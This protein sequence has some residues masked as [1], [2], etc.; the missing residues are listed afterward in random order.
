[1]RA[2]LAGTLFDLVK[3]EGMSNTTVVVSG[4]TP[5]NRSPEV[6][7]RRAP[8][9]PAGE[10]VSSE[11]MQIT[12]QYGQPLAPYYSRPA[13]DRPYYGQGFYGQPVYQQQQQYYQPSTRY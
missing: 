8:I 3:A 4:R 1:L 10:I 12:P 13:Y 6:A 5:S 7:R 2:A 11:S 9:A